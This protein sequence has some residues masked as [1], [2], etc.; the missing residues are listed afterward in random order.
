MASLEEFIYIDAPPEAVYR[1]L[2]DLAQYHRYAPAN[3]RYGRVL[4]PRAD[5]PGARI[6]A[7]VK[8]AGPFS[9]RLVMQLLAL[10]PPRCVIAG[11]PDA[12]NFLTRWTLEP[13]P[14]GTQVTVRTD[15][16]NPS[17][18][19]GPLRGRLETMLQRTYRETLARLKALAER[20]S[21]A[22]R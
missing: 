2:A 22:R 19:P 7:R 9:Q 18:V 17:G 5:E 6:E 14:P 10:E 4:T 8:L 20:E 21:P 3:V 16:I 12:S 13:E 1:L 15:F 11:P